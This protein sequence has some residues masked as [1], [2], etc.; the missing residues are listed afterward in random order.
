MIRF[1]VIWFWLFWFFRFFP[2]FTYFEFRHCSGKLVKFIIF[3]LVLFSINEDW[4]NHLGLDLY[5]F[6]GWFLLHTFFWTQQ[7]L[8]EDEIHWF[9]MIGSRKVFLRIVIEEGD[10]ISNKYFVLP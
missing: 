8:W 1:T 6:V 9:W 3:K 10:S 7:L 4:I 2:F 5:R